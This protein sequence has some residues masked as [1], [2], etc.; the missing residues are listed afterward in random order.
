MS[1]S[2]Q[3][4]QI[5][6]EEARAGLAE[7]GNPIGAAIISPD[8]RLLGRGRNTRNQNGSP[9]LHG[10]TAAFDSNRTLAKSDWHG[11][12]LYTTMSPCPMCAGAAMWFQCAR[13]IIGENQSMS[14]RE[15]LMRSHGIEVIVLDNQECKDLVAKYEELYPNKQF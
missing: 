15:E 1:V 6:L 12:T 2:D 13:V 5:A 7:G 4:F 14:G 9:I 8:G 11:S 3:G 10:E